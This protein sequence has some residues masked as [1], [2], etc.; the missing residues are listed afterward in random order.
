MQL[1]CGDRRLRCGQRIDDF[2]GPSVMKL[3]ARFMLDCARIGLKPIDM[4]MKTLVLLLQPLHLHLKRLCLFALACEGGQ[5]VVAEDHPIS[6][7]QSK[8]TYSEGGRPLPPNVH[9]TPSRPGNARKTGLLYRLISSHRQT[10]LAPKLQIAY[11]V[12]PTRPEKCIDSSAVEPYLSIAGG[13]APK[14][15]ASTCPRFGILG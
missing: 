8:R 15:P 5:T 12:S 14:D 6:H 3:L 4:T 11:L 7:D 10:D 9:T 1:A 13:T 2:P